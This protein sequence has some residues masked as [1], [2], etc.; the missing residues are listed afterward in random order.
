MYYIYRTKGITKAD[1]LT[2]MHTLELCIMT[3]N[4]PVFNLTRN[5]NNRT[6]TNIITRLVKILKNVSV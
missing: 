5:E 2:S 3:R 4:H 1:A 6:K